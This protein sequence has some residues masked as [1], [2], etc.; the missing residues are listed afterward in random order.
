M[1]NTARGTFLKV[2]KMTKTKPEHQ[3]DR[4]KDAARELNADESPDA[5]DRIMGRLDLTKKPEP[6]KKPSKK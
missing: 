3:I 5:L 2:W 1:T 6:D 4:F